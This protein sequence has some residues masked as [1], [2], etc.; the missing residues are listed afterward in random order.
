MTIGLR[1]INNDSEL[2]IDSDYVNPTFVQKLEFNSTPTSTET[3]IVTG[4][5]L[6]NLHAGYT[7]REYTTGIAPLNNGVYIVLW[8][9][10]DN[11]DVDVY[12]NFP[13]SV[14]ESNKS[15]TCEVYAGVSGSYTLPTAYIFATDVGSLSTLYSEGPALRMYNSSPSKQKTFDSQF[16]QLI[17]YYISDNFFP[18][19]SQTNTPVSISKPTNPIFLL[20]KAYAIYEIDAVNQP[21]KRSQTLVDTT[22]KLYGST[23]YAKEISTFRNIVTASSGVLYQYGPSLQGYKS[24]LVADGDLYQGANGSSVS[25]TNPSYTLSSNF[26]PVNETTSK[27]FTITLTTTNVTNGTV[28]YY[29]V[30]GISAADLTSGGLTGSFV[31]QNNTATASFTVATDN[32]T[33]G[34][35]TFLLTLNGITQSVSVNILDTSRNAPA[36]TAVSATSVNEGSSIYADFN[37]L[38]NDSIYPVTFDIVGISEV[39][40]AYPDIT[41]S[42]A[43]PSGA[44]YTRVTINARADLRPEGAETFQVRA[45]I[46][47]NYYYTSNITIN[48]TTTSSVSAASNWVVGTD[49]T[50]T[51]TV[52]G[53]LGS[54][55][56]L[57]SN[58]TSAID[59]KAGSA[60]SWYVN[61]NSFSVTTT[62]QAKALN[63]G[64]YANMGLYLKKG[65]EFLTY[66]YITTSKP[67][68]VLTWATSPLSIDEGQAGSLQL[69]YTNLYAGDYVSFGI[70]YGTNVN[71]TDV[72]VTTPLTN[73]STTGNGS[74]S[75]AYNVAADRVTEGAEYFQ[76]YATANS[77]VTAYSSNI[78]I[79]DTSQTP[80]YG[81]AALSPD[82][83]FQNNTRYTSVTLTNVNGYVY[84]PRSNNAAVTCQTNSFTVTSNSFTTTLTWDIADVSANVT[85]TLELRRSSPSGTADAS[86][87]VLVKDAPAAGTPIGSPYCENYGVYP[88]TRL[89]QYANGSGGVSTEGTYLSTACGY[90]APYWTLTCSPT[91]VGEGNSFTISLA[92]NQS[93][94]FG[95]TISGIDSADIGGTSLTGTLANGGTRTINVTADESTEGTE[96]FAVSLDN[97]QSSASVT[98]SDT[99]TTPSGGL[100]QT[101]STSGQVAVYFSMYWQLYLNGSANAATY[102]V[103]GGSAPPG[104]NFSLSG[105]QMTYTLSG[106][107]TTA[108]TYSFT[109]NGFRG[110][111]QYS[112]SV[113]IT[114][115]APAYPAYG[116]PN[117]VQYC[118]GTTLYQ[119]YNDGSGGTYASVVAYNSTSCGYV[120]PSYA[121]YNTWSDLANN[122]ASSFYVQ[123]NAANGVT[124]T[125]SI[126]GAG[127]GRV[128]ISP[129]SSTISGNGYV[130]TF[131]TVTS[132][133]PTSNVAAQSVTISVAGQSFSF[134]VQAYAPVAVAPTV[135]GIRVGDQ[136]N[137]YAG[138][139][140]YAIITFS[141]PITST[142]YLQVEFNL[143]AYTA[144][145]GTPVN[146]YGGGTATAQSHEFYLG[147]TEGIVYTPTNPGNFNTTL[148]LRARSI[149][150]SGTAITSY[151]GYASFSYKATGT[152]QA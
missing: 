45:L 77:S 121:I 124:L 100:V 75:V 79:N 106:T 31:V 1:I 135:I 9:L 87:T 123:S 48:D 145:Y 18:P 130:N 11:G 51:V 22:Y 116:T 113:T 10:P 14:M 61:S 29:T 35:E 38:Y 90:V 76:L 66:K 129:T 117:G 57:Y 94:N 52:T 119:N 97:G 5:Y 40:F 47:G 68:P 110:R 44:S 93:G 78:T 111:F 150:S 115:A 62:Y 73:I 132:T 146:N 80:A 4:N 42:P 83:W 95:Y 141:G 144:Y 98:I 16:T 105:D 152:I 136:E 17:P 147:A 41:L 122:A 103:T 36:W 92:T 125:P 143:G 74:I 34:Q 99:S 118:I 7:K 6:D 13:T 133:L 109:V 27:T 89:Q 59:V 32:S 24:L 139:Q 46:D 82:T 140:S 107:P 137:V 33:E 149:N 2:L 114:I 3:G 148:R 131:F 21:G 101:G 63:P 30:T 64:T 126:S 15:L 70:S 65:E 134:T 39:E 69:N 128:S 25:T 81:I 26:N 8:K 49:N 50:V 60:S 23:I 28:V 43:I 71:S 67:T 102:T 12:Y 53:G 151:T 138:S 86:T 84:Y 54:T 120:A 37:S 72:W 58:E 85:V 19:F 88:Y 20:P 91:S 56:Y 112:K 104:L 55:V 142:T 108:G 96:Y 127:A